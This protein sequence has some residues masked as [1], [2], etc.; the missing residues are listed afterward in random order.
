MVTLKQSKKPVSAAQAMI[1]DI[2]AELAGGGLSG[3]R[4]ATLEAQLARWQELYPPE[5]ASEP[6]EATGTIIRNSR[7]G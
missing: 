7:P 4:K 5:E 6:I 1:N 3:V 2:E